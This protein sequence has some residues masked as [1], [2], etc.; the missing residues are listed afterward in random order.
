M[1]TV[2][3]LSYPAWPHCIRPS[4]PSIKFGGKHQGL[5]E[6]ELPISRAGLA[7]PHGDALATPAHLRL[8]KSP[9]QKPLVFD[10]SLSLVLCL[11]TLHAPKQNASHIPVQ[12]YSQ[13]EAHVSLTLQLNT[14]LTLQQTGVS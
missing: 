5:P 13:P 14:T 7:L 2:S 12:A 6:T 1:P 8:L 10:V 4:Q 11:A 3:H 9:S